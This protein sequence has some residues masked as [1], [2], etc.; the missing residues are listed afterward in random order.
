MTTRKAAVA[1]NAVTGRVVSQADREAKQLMDALTELGSKA[2]SSNAIRFEGTAIVL[3]ASLAGPGGYEKARKILR[4]QEELEERTFEMSRTFPYRPYDGA[5][6]FDRAMIKLFG[7]AGIGKSW[8]DFF[9]NEHHPQLISVPVGVKETVQVPWDEVSFSPLDALFE[10]GYVA[11][12]NKGPLSHISVQCPRKHAAIIE[13]FFKVVEDELANRSI[14]RGKAIDGDTHPGFWDEKKVDARTVVY[15]GDTVEQL[16]RNVWSVIDY[17]DAMR[18]NRLPLKRAVLLEGEWGTGKTL[19]GALTAQHATRA[20]WTFI[21]V[22]PEDDPLLALQTA[23]LYAP[24][25]VWIEDADNLANKSGKRAQISAV[26][27]AMDNAAVKNSEL[28]VG[29]TTNYPDQIEKGML[30]PGRIDAVIHFG[31]VDPDKVEPLIRATVDDHLLGEID[32]AQVA[33]AF[34]GYVPAYAVEA[35]QR[36]VRYSIAANAGQPSPLATDDLVLAAN[37]LKRQLAMMRDAGE[38]QDTAMLEVALEAAVTRAAEA[39]AKRTRLVDFG[40]PFEVEQPSG[41]LVPN[42]QG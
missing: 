6:A 13:G 16:N 25:V 36:A 20:G 1:D 33:E 14:Y 41:A 15:N 23:R 34:T 4:E 2:V 35:I 28:M 27:D 40:S 11:D 32:F 21:L 31:E 29:F 37:G 26:L 5:A 42:G 8:T 39:V 38:A 18:A 19:A 22:R 7:T 17:A 12:R 10:I 9:G 24:A 30:R 3:P